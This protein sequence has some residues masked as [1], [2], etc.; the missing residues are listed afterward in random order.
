MTGVEIDLELHQGFIGYQAKTFLRPKPNQWDF[1]LIFWETNM[2]QLT[3]T[4]ILLCYWA[5]IHTDFKFFQRKQHHFQRMKTPPVRTSDPIIRFRSDL[6]YVPMLGTFLSYERSLLRRFGSP[7]LRF[8]LPKKTVKTF[9][10]SE[11]NFS[12][13]SDKTFPWSDKTFPWSEPNLSMEWAKLFHGE[14]QLFFME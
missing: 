1:E 10:G 2:N 9:P 11:Q 5:N 4:W 6:R 13:E 14:W 7:E 8:D 3:E 12:M